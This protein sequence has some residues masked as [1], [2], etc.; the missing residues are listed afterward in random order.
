MFREQ[1]SLS[2][3][4]AQPTNIG[5]EVCSFVVQV[6]PMIYDNE[7]MW[8]ILYGVVPHVCLFNKANGMDAALGFVRFGHSR[9][10][11]GLSMKASLVQLLPPRSCTRP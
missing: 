1:T 5:E 6:D 3:L 2:T 7:E 9:I 11:I 4:S 10:E 8:A